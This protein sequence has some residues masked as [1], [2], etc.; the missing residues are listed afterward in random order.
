MQE[1]IRMIREKTGLS[2]TAFGDALGVS[3][4]TVNRW[5][6]GKALPNKIAQ[7]GMH[8][9]AKDKSISIVSMIVDKIQQEEYKLNLDDQKLVLYHGSKAGIGGKISPISRDRCDFGKGFYMG[10]APEQPLSLV[11]DFEQSR[12]YIV[13]LDLKGLACVTVDPD[14]DWAM[15]VAFNRGKMTDI[16]GTSLYRKYEKMANDADIIIGSIV[17][18]RMFFVLDNFFQGNITDAALVGSL[19]AL[20]LGLQYVA[21][22]QKACD[23]VHIEKEIGLSYLERICIQDIAEE[24]R[25]KGISLADD[26]CKAYRREGV[27]FD[28]ILRSAKEELR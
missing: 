24:N 23:H 9:L 7:L 5:E 28:E 26:I 21:V 17:N 18:D 25:E 22:T 13:S 10:T 4:S 8:D 27:F 6:N 20:D 19:S 16:K 14:I 11:C 3:F 1:M 15:L 2:Q 12:L